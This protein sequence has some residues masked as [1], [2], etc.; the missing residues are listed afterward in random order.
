MLS[1]SGLLHRFNNAGAGA[2]AAVHVP[3]LGVPAGQFLA[4]TGPS[5]SG[6]TTLL[7]LLSGLLRPSQGSIVWSG[8]DITGMR[9]GQRDGWRRRHAGFV[10]QNFNLIEE[11]TAYQN[12]TVAA[13]FS[14]LSDR[15]VREPARRLLAQLGVPDERRRVDT[16]SRGEQ[17][18]I[19]LARALLFDPPVLFADEPTASLD[20]TNSQALA[21][22]FQTL[23]GAG[24]CVIVVS[25]DP[26]V[27]QAADRIIQ[28]DH[29]QLVSR[30]E[31]VAA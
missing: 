3:E 4:I 2:R 16:Y 15:Q 9:E 26:V 30:T 19:A 29:G 22:Q 7:Y 12:V 14:A 8:Q 28:L 18:R 25:H 6:K 27:I 21:T 11:M 5:G 10:F 20:V 23:A 24:K 17:Q 1:V 13:Y 31:A